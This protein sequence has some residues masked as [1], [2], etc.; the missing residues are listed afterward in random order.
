[1]I[2]RPPRSTLS[3]S[4]AASDVYK[5]QAHISFFYQVGFVANAATIVSGLMAE[6]AQNSAYGAMSFLFAS[7][8]VPIMF[9]WV[10]S[11]D[12]WLY[13]GIHSYP[14]LDFAGSGVVHMVG[15]T[16][17]FIGSWVLGPRLRRWPRTYDESGSPSPQQPTLDVE[18]PPKKSHGAEPPNV[19]NGIVN[20]S[21][22]DDAPSEA[23]D[24][25]RSSTPPGHG[26]GSCEDS[27]NSSTDASEMC[28]SIPGFGNGSGGDDAEMEDEDKDEDEDEESGGA[29][30]C[31]HN[32]F[33]HPDQNPIEP[34]NKAY[35]VIGGMLLWYGWLAFNSGSVPAVQTQVQ[36]Q[37]V[38]RT[39]INTML[40]PAIAVITAYLFKS[41]YPWDVCTLISVA[42][43][44]L[45]A[46]T[47]PCA[48]VHPA[49]CIPIGVMAFFT[50]RF[51]RNVA[52]NFKVDDPV[53][54]FPVHF[55]GG[56]LGALS[57]GLFAD[58]VI[59]NEYYLNMY[60]HDCG[61]LFYV[62]NPYLLGMQCLGCVAMI[63][64]TAV[65]AFMFFNLSHRFGRLRIR[66]QDENLGID[67]AKGHGEAYP[68]FALAQG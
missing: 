53:D 68:Y 48:L 7:F 3:S 34:V 9:H 32:F 14:Y 43:T 17:G 36:Q 15:A 41:I 46:I 26:D 2:R 23:L 57:V 20:A 40:T 47:A 27:Q 67:I 28:S 33:H 1:M 61:G 59:I 16:A 25:Y 21:E 50:H 55:G 38:A 18:A 4:S 54:A 64:W 24:E 56:L 37:A 6:R 42:L 63:S 39:T 29:T 5:R 52:L 8:V 10:W 60:P 22:D 12:G 44:A 13:K 45:A 51:F 62:G 11:P 30:E 19:E 49:F 31:C 58:D 66:F 65:W 35:V